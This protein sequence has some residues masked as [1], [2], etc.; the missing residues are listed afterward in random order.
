MRP[1]DDPDDVV[2]SESVPF[3]RELDTMLGTGGME[4]AGARS[5]FLVV[6]VDREFGEK[7]FL[8]L[9]ADATLRMKRV[10]VALMDLGDSGPGGRDVEGVEGVPKVPMDA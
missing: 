2:S 10:A 8:A 5:P 6:E 7:R 4:S 9:G 1:L 3:S